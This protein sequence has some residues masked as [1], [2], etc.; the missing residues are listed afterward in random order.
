MLRRIRPHLTYANV[1]VTLLAFVVLGGGAAYAANTI[2]SLDVI[3]ES[4][5]S[6]DIKD[7]AV[8]VADVGQGAVATDEIA[9]GQVRAADLGAGEVRTGNVANDNL[10]GV[11][12]AQNAL[13]GADIDESTLS[14]IGGGGPAGGDLTGTYPNPS[15]RSFAVTSDKISSRSVGASQLALPEGWHYI[16]DPGEPGFQ[17]GWSNYDAGSHD[18]AVWQHAAY[19][20]DTNNVVHLRGLVKG[21]TIGAT[22]FTLPSNYCPWYYHLAPTL[23]GDALARLTMTY[24][25]PDCSLS[26]SG[27]A[28]NSY[29]ALDPMSYT[30][31][32]YEHRTAGASAKA[33]AGGSLGGRRLPTGDAKAGRQGR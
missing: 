17:N 7:G 16:G 31:Y 22:I 25:T 32:Y 3:D 11:D 20:I 14:N 12:V 23:A 24:I 8:K 2:G 4:L 27:A 33:S 18:G 26:V 29:V 10:T 21:G 9:N 5:L 1:M 15:I 19:A 28:S 13:K 30:V 6:Q